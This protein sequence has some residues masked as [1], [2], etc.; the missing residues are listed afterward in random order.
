VKR[1]RLLRPLSD[2][3]HQALALARRARRAAEGAQDA[4]ALAKAWREVVERF[5]AELEPHFRVEERWLFPE[6]ESAG[7][8]TGVARARADH[9][10]LRELA[11][12]GGGA[13]AARELGELLE[14]HVRFEERELFPSAERLLELWERSA[15]EAARQACVAAALS[16]YED[17]LLRGLCHEGAFEAAIGAIR[18][19]P[20]AA[21]AGE[22]D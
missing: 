15:G 11:R 22:S 5:A 17:A 3:H 19:V 13:D 6:L 18:D 9:A 4:A 16:A 8:V 14:R 21:R 10:R 1:H 20:L 7:E 12:G 2:D